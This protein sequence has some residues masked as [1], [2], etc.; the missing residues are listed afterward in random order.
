MSVISHTHP[1]WRGRR[2]RAA[3]GP[4]WALVFLAATLTAPAGA[5][6]P[7]EETAA[8]AVRTPGEA[9]DPV[10]VEVVRMADAKVTEPVILRWLE[11]SGHRPARVGSRELIELKRA[12]ASDKVTEKLLDLAGSFAG[13]N[14]AEHAERSEHG[15]GPDPHASQSAAAQPAP[16]DGSRAGA[17]SGPVRSAGAGAGA[18]AASF[19]WS[20]Q[21]LPNFLA[22]DV[23]WDLYVYLDGRY[24]AWV[25]TPLVSFLDKPL[26]FDY[27]LA[28]GHHVLRLIE[29]R[30][31]RKPNTN[32][33]DNQA[34]VAPK[35]LELEVKPEIAGRVDLHLEVR[36]RGGPVSMRVTQGDAEVAKAQ[37]SMPLPEH[38]QPLCE[39]A[40]GQ[41]EPCLRWAD[42]WPGIASLASREQI[43]GELERQGFHPDPVRTPK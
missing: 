37:P 29:E 21:Y 4:L 7:P 3:L 42:L 17:A 24:M 1:A 38:W 22:D 30:H 41:H 19:H 2:R 20:I 23:R 32:E 27:S 9:L 25:K 36:T 5:T 14:R 11:T 16:G 31:V 18:G 33:W 26:E 15:G 10:V 8:A 13:T 34:R 40:P 35:A 39:E 12:G 6:A 43:R 28:P